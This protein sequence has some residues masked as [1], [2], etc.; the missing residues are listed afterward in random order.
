[1]TVCNH[2]PPL[3]VEEKTSQVTEIYIIMQQS[4]I[5]ADY[6]S[7]QSQSSNTDNIQSEERSCLPAE[8]HGLVSS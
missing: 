1:M 8:Y 3:S 6:Q 4:N 7:W 5:R 2:N